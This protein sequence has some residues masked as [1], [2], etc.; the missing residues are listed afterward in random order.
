MSSNPN[1]RTK[2]L[3]VRI[4]EDADQRL[5]VLSRMLGLPRST[6]VALALGLYLSQQERAFGIVK[7]VAEKVGGEMGQ[8]PRED[9]QAAGKQEKLWPSKGPRGKRGVH[10]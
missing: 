7:H 4:T 2:S 3:Q 1:K 10:V 8:P 6:C 9:L 5:T